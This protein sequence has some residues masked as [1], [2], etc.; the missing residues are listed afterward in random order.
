MQIQL[1]YLPDRD[2]MVF[3]ASKSKL[4]SMEIGGGQSRTYLWAFGAVL[5]VYVL[6]AFLDVMDVDAAQYALMSKEMIESGSYLQVMERGKDYLDKPPLLFWFTA[7]AFNIF[8]I[9]NFSYRIFPIISTVLGAYATYRLGKLYYDSRVGKLA[10]L[11][12]VSSQA[13]FLINHDVRTDT[14]LTNAI[15]WAIWQLAEFNQTKKLKYLLGAFVG[16]GLAML[17]KGPIGLMV[18]VLAF[19]TDFV[20][21][22]Q[23]TA[24]F[25]WQWLLGLGIVLLILAPMLYGLYYQFDN[26]PDKLMFGNKNNS[27]IYFYF[28]K[29]SFG[30]LTGENDF[31]R[32]TGAVDRD[33]F[34]FVHS[35][36]WSYLPW[37]LLFFWAL[38]QDT[39]QLFR[40]GF[41]INDQEEA[42]TWGGV[43][44][45]LIAL[46][47]SQFKLPHYIYV[48]FPLATLITAKLLTKLIYQSDQIR[49]FKVGNGF[50]A[51]TVGVLVILA[52]L[53]AWY[54]FAP[55]QWTD[56]LIVSLSELFFVGTIYYIFFSK[57]RFQKLIL[58]PL[59]AILGVNLLLNGHI[60]PQLFGYQA[61]SV[62]ARYARAE[63]KV[64]P[65]RFYVILKNNDDGIYV[66]SLDFYSQKTLAG[67]IKDEKELLDIAKSGKCWLYADSQGL[68]AVENLNQ[69]TKI[70]KKAFRFHISQLNITFLNPNTRASE[71]KD[72]Y[73]LEFSLKN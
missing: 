39:L 57:N 54:C 48:I 25:R 46:S 64:N 28:W 34:F 66:H 1:G 23:W 56:Y 4:K 20:M 33:Y 40:K 47:F 18:P 3:F 67:E 22:R 58:P 2:K 51:F 7:L 36:A 49:S 10:A 52:H 30:R 63:V 45:P 62:V 5:G 43:V 42:L 70:L 12:L 68:K 19:A 17:A 29:Q 9:F 26:Q 15:I 27:G 72:M 13:Y 32:G 61:G 59:L 24:F 55:S 65:A 35:F 73:L 60:Y 6:G 8:G 21:K 69:N 53:L 41:K 38:G 16:I 31:V 37:A 14:M 44:L 11:T 50:L 71:L